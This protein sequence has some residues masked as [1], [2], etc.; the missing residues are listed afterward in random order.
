MS[1]ERDHVQGAMMNETANEAAKP[2]RITVVSAGVS[3][4]SSTT[5]LG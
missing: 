2:Y 3:D 1:A 4:P 5:R